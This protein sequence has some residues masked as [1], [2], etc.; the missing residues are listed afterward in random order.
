MALLDDLFDAIGTS[1]IRERERE[2]ERE[3]MHHEKI[4]LASK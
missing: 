3:R 1:M 4:G 2:R